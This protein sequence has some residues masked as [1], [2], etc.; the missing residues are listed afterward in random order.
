MANLA[1]GNTKT[2]GRFNARAVFAFHMAAASRAVAVRD[3]GA[4]GRAV[5]RMRMTRVYGGI[6]NAGD[7]HEARLP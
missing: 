7:F 2:N 6:H 3:K 5:I 4:L 1:N